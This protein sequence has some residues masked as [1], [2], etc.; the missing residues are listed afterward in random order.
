MDR[1]VPFNGPEI[2]DEPDDEIYRITSPVH[3]RII[4]LIYGTGMAL[5]TVLFFV[6]GRMTAWVNIILYVLC[7]LLLGLNMWSSVSYVYSRDT[8]YQMLIGVEGYA[9]SM[10]PYI[11]TIAV[12]TV[13]LSRTDEQNYDFKYSILVSIISLVAALLVVWVPQNNRWLMR[14]LRD[15]KTVLFI[16]GAVFGI[17]SVYSVI[18]DIPTVPPNGRPTDRR[19][20]KSQN[21]CQCHNIPQIP[22]T[23]QESISPFDVID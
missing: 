13:T 22:T 10:I 5:A 18:S 15:I 14:Y 7:M 9:S 17:S 23:V 16:I 11:V 4:Y 8:E 12:L 3:R 19:N 6:I 2:E 1:S 21:D 20:R